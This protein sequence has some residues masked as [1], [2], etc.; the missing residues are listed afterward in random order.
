MNATNG[1]SLAGI[2]KRMI[3]CLYNQLCTT[4]TIFKCCYWR[5][6]QHILHTR[7]LY[8]NPSRGTSQNL[9]HQSLGVPY[10]IS[11]NSIIQQ[12][13]ITISVSYIP[14]LN[15]SSPLL[16]PNLLSLQRKTHHQNSIPSTPV[17]HFTR[18]AIHHPHPRT[19]PYILLLH[20]PHAIRHLIT[21]SKTHAF[22]IPIPM[23]PKSFA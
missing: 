8:R 13:C 10:L 4:S 16:L 21:A 17:R 19:L 12:Q 9:V 23:M 6:L 22:T 18:H 7:D 5:F 15:P 2:A 20:K 14:I 3:A 11:Q 1:C